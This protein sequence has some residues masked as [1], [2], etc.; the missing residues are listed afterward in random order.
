MAPAFKSSPL[1]E[2]ARLALRLVSSLPRFLRDPWR[3]Q[4]VRAT[5]GER[6]ARRE[7]DFLALARTLIY[8]RA[9]SPYR[10]L[11]ARAGCDHDDLAGLVRRDGLEGA[12]RRLLREGVYLT[13]DELKGRRPVVR[14]ATSF[15]VDPVGLRNPGL[16]DHVARESGGSRG[17]PTTT[18][19]DLRGIREQALDLRVFLDAMASADA[20][21]AVWYVPGGTAV[22][23]NLRLSAAGCRPVRWFSQIDPA[24]PSLPSRYRWSGTI[25]RVGSLLAG[26]PLPAPRH[27]SLDAA[28]IIARWVGAILRD[29]HAPHLWTFASNAVVVCQAAA[30]DG[31]DVAG[32]RFILSG[33]PITAGRIAA[34]RSAGAIAVPR[35]A[36]SE[37]GQLGYGCLAPAWPD[38]MHFPSDLHALIQPDAD[39]PPRGLSAGALLLTSLRPAARLVLLNTSIGDIATVGERACGCPLQAAGWTTHLHD[40]RSEEKVTV[41][42]MT[43]ADPDVRRVLDETLPARFGGSAIDYQLKEE[44]AEGGGARLRL[45][46]HPQVGP[47]DEAAVA[48]AFLEALGRG[49]GVERMMERAWRDARVLRVERRPPEATASG[50]IHHLRQPRAAAAAKAGE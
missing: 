4:A 34:V 13:A 44:E 42:G 43:F 7:A 48:D 10:R 24:S 50:K 39:T 1:F 15:Q 26:R 33:E 41:G 20:P 38:D 40:V 3:P 6:L 14:G 8:G 19:L 11:L 28:S 36:A 9:E 32:A 46:V 16:V 35:F 2:D 5:L 45:F 18:M 30:R 49:P 47:L 12:L 22:G 29:G 23:L 17:A 21:H 25:V 27:V 37:S 31:V